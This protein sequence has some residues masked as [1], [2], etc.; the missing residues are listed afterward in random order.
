MDYFDLHCDTAYELYHKKADLYSNN[1]AV[2]DRKL[3]GL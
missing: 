3:F 2:S 1:L